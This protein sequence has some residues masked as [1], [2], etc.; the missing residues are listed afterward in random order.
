MAHVTFRTGGKQ[1]R[2]AEGERLRIPSM[3]GEPGNKISFEDVLAIDGENPQFGKP[4][5]P[6]AKV[7]AEIVLQGL[8]KKLVVFKFRRRKR[9][10]RKN[11]HRQT[12][13]EVKI[14]RISA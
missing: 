3:E 6:G 11:G 5:I 12:F 14:T 8:D 13:T 2:A 9:H 4:T 7:E 10:A 1:F